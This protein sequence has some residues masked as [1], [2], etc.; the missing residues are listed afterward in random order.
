[1]LAAPHP[2]RVFIGFELY[3]PSIATTLIKLENA[4]ASNPRVI[5]ADA[6][7]GQ[8][9]LFGP[10]DLDELWTFFADPWHKKRHHKR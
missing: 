1:A 4:G 10:A 6:T 2:E 8:D 7:A 3:L 5:M 9:H